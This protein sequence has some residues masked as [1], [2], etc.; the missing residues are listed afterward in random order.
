MFG[1][2]N[3]T[4]GLSNATYNLSNPLIISNEMSKYI[5]DTTNKSLEKYKNK[6]RLTN[7]STAL[8]NDYATP[9]DGSSPFFVLLPF[10]SLMLFLAGYR[11]FRLKN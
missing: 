11:L 2:S 4:C 5:K 9:N 8:T 1:L 7:T 10:V 3:A 6:V